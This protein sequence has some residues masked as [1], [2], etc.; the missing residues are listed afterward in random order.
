VGIFQQYNLQPV[1][2]VNQISQLI[3]DQ[4]GLYGRIRVRC[5]AVYQEQKSAWTNALT[6]IC[7]WPSGNQPQAQPPRR[8]PEAH[9]LEEWFGLE[10]LPQLLDQ[11]G[12][13][14]KLLLQGEEVLLDS[15]SGINHRQF[16]PRANR[17]SPL[18][19]WLYEAARGQTPPI[20]YEPLLAP[21][22]PFYADGLHAMQEWFGLPELSQTDSRIG[23]VVMFFP[24]CR[25]GIES[26]ALGDDGRLT[27]RPRYGNDKYKPGMEL[28]GAWAVGDAR[29]TF[30]MSFESEVTLSVP[31]GATRFAVYVV[32]A[33][34]TIF[35][36]HDEMSLWVQGGPRL[37]GSL[38]TGE[39]GEV[40]RRALKTGE[41]DIAEYKPFIEMGNT[42]QHEIV[43]SVIAFAN[44]KGG[45]IL[46]GIDKHCT[47]VGIEQELH[48]MAQTSSES[49]D[50]AIEK[51]KGWLR[52]LIGDSL[53]RS[54][55]PE[56]HLVPVEGHKVLALVIPDGKEKPYAR[57]R[58]NDIWVRKG[59]NNVRP[60]PD[61]DLPDLLEPPDSASGVFGA[62]PWTGSGRKRRQ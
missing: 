62:M 1:D 58:S 19:G 42:K 18:S 48:R 23:E 30:E 13:S 21:R 6:H 10:T 44:T 46:F 24:E 15:Q 38:P 60:D 41:C 52:R 12:V 28:K 3:T 2:W 5:V 51:Y 54:I 53:N 36:F 50:G 47:V 55:V 43:E 32:G 49:F 26:I 7:V 4:A 45:V 61:T 34:G 35:D 56:F 25:A 33:D 27:V 29:R 22:L 31:E 40:I 20:P 17:Y 39:A 8:Y 14:R 37:L 9:L 59:S 11:I 57:V 16:H